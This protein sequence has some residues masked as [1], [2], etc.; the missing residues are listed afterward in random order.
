MF[1]ALELET[2]AKIQ[3]GTVVHLKL[4]G[5]LIVQGSSER[6]G[7]VYL[8]VR[9]ARFTSP[10]VD[11]NSQKAMEDVVQEFETPLAV[12]FE[13]NGLV[14]RV[15][16]DESLN[17]QVRSIMR[18]LAAYMQF[19]T[20]PNTDASTWEADEADTAGR[21]QAHYVRQGKARFK[22]RKQRYTELLAAG[23]NVRQS[24]TLEIKQSEQTFSFDEDDGLLSLEVAEAVAASGDFVNGL[25]T[26]TTLSLRFMEESPTKER[27]SG[28]KLASVQLFDYRHGPG[29]SRAASRAQVGGRSV[30]A[31]LGLLDRYENAETDD[32]VRERSKAVADLAALMRL[33]D[34]AVDQILETIEDGSPHARRLWSAL[35]QA[36]TP[37]A[38]SALRHLIKQ[39]EWDDTERRTQMIGLSLVSRPDPETIAFLREMVDDPKQ[40][41]QARY[42]I[43]TAV[44]HLKD[45]D[46]EAA[47][48][49]LNFLVEKLNNAPNNY[50]KVQY[51]DSIGNAGHPDSLPL[52]APMTLDRDAGMRAAS[53]S[54]M[55]FLPGAEVDK[56]LASMAQSDSSQQVRLAAVDALSARSP[57]GPVLESLYNVATSGARDTQKRARSA[58]NKLALSH[59]EATPLLEA[60]KQHDLAV[61]RS[62]PEVT[63]G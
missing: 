47:K 62:L 59:A 27:I 18:S 60:I 20:Q 16:E 63:G 11:Q 40:G 51:V 4:A 53:A 31:F 15:R 2:V 9:K 30:G 19:R 57:S 3:Q 35:A 25:I 58:I 52:L 41:L 22:K 17:F 24:S 49:Q 55:R 28:N 5:E 50:E 26:K 43:G 36:G 1:Y 12:Q 61:A 54:A 45:S 21:Y 13:S 42:G 29:F 23:K 56:M 7:E 6:P 44:H 8:F 34:T 32:E 48:T 10:T 37:R 39:P 38:Q 46:P 33:D 14:N